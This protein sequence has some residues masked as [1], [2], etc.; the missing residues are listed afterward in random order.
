[1]AL[2]ATVVVVS[3]LA[4]AEPSIS[5]SGPPDLKEVLNLLLFWKL[6]VWPKS[7]FVARSAAMVIVIFISITISLTAQ[8]AGL[9]PET[10]SVLS[11]SPSQ[12]G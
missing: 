11:L 1:M 3:T 8:N 12:G 2:E 9:M 4:L 10:R 5:L 6:H 7:N